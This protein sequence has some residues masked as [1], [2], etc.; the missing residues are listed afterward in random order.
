MV[1]Y[2][3]N[4]APDRQYLGRNCRGGK[5]HSKSVLL[6]CLILPEKTTTDLES[7]IYCIKETC[8]LSKACQGLVPLFHA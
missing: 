4:K 7:S 2:R 6:W 5:L 3:S 8:A 1:R